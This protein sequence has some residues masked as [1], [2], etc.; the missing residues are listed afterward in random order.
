VDR[1][2]GARVIVVACY[3]DLCGD[4]LA[5]STAEILRRATAAERRH[6]FAE[7]SGTGAIACAVSAQTIR[8]RAPMLQR[9]LTL[10]P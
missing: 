3:V 7:R 1:I 5:Y 4:L 10:S 6:S 9:R 8:R 2:G